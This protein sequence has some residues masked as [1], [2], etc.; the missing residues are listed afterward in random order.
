MVQAVQKGH[1]AEKK[2]LH[3]VVQ[4][5]VPR[6]GLYQRKGFNVKGFKKANSI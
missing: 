5:S 4:I 3:V 1:Q 6:L 2:V